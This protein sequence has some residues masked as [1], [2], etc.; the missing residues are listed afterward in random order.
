LFEEKQD[1][2]EVGEHEQNPPKQQQPP[3][4]ESEQQQIHLPVVDFKHTID[5]NPDDDRELLI[6]KG[7]CC[8]GLKKLIKNVTDNQE[9]LQDE[10]LEM[11]GKLSKCISGEENPKF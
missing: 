6:S 5:Y 4:N 1:D 3:E 8:E 7:S 11:R 9:D 2:D 10:N